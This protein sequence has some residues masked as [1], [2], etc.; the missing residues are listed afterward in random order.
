[1][2]T[3]DPADHI[4]EDMV[5]C[6]RVNYGLDTM[7]PAE[8][9]RWWESSCDGSAPAGAVAALGLCLAERDSLLR[10]WA[11]EQGQRTAA[12]DRAERAELERDRLRAELAAAPVTCQ[13]YGPSVKVPCAECNQTLVDSQELAEL[14]ER[15]AERER[16]PNLLPVIQWLERGC[17]P[18]EAAKELRIYQQMLAHNAGDHAPRSGRV[19]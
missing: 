3:Q 7:T 17:D 13:T 9:M 4:T 14:R 6:W 2:S 8:A 10:D 11:A 12:V 19:D 16:F 18:K 15:A 5:A 1:M